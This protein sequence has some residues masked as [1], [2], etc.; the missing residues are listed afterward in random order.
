M[1]FYADRPARRTTQVLLDL[2]LV[3]WIWISGTLARTVDDA[4]LGLATPGRKV[5]ASAGDLA[6]NLRSAGRRVSGV[7]LIGD[8][9]QKPFDRAGAAA[10]QLVDAGN[11]QV[12]AVE[13]LAFWL[14]I[15]VAAIPIVIAIS[16]WLPPRVRFV[17]RATAGQHFLESG[18]DLDL[19]ALRAMTQQP[20]HV[21]ARVSDDPV[22]AW[23]RG[24]TDVI[25]RLADLEPRDSGLRAPAGLRERT[26]T[27]S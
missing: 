8:D 10:Y 14:G 9:V 24:D 2:A 17:R 13:S 19:F 18:A 4:T 11:S 23:R 3:A 22:A 27:S 25:D 12:S 16:Y 21:L 26:R 1:K 7:P 15:A 6:E 5:A 20:L